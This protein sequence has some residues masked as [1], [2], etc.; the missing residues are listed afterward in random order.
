[1]QEPGF[2]S[3]LGSSDETLQNLITRVQKLLDDI[4][5]SSGDGLSIDSSQIGDLQ[6]IHERLSMLIAS[7]SDRN[8][9]P[10]DG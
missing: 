2:N 1:V 3:P 5:A 4:P 8:S 10:P 7:I 6:E 9:H